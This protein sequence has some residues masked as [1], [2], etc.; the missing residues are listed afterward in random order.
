MAISMSPAPIA[1]TSASCLSRKLRWIWR[2]A[3]KACTA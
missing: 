1:R 2:A 3:S